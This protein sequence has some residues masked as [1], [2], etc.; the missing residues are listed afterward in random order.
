MGGFNSLP[1]ASALYEV[2]AVILQ[3]R[4]RDRVNFRFG[5]EWKNL[6]SQVNNI[7]ERTNDRETESYASSIALES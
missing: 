6:A 3:R 2:Q 1:V 4:I 5:A 7:Y